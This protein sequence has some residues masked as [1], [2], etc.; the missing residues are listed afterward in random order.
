M[1]RLSPLAFLTCSLLSLCTACMPHANEEQCLQACTYTLDSIHNDLRLQA[2]APA[3]DGPID[4]TACTQACLSQIVPNEY[5]CLIRSFDSYQVE[6]CFERPLT[7]ALI[8][9]QARLTNPQIQANFRT[10]H[11]RLFPR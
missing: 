11:Q 1:T 3:P 5:E 6:S 9:D 10:R 8:F 2:N 4:A 7:N